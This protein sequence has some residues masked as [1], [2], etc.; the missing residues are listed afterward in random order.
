MV[1]WLLLYTVVPYFVLLL[2]RCYVLSKAQAFRRSL[3]R[4]ADFRTR[5][6]ERSSLIVAGKLVGA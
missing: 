5:Y 3:R 4:N 6:T 2:L 1:G